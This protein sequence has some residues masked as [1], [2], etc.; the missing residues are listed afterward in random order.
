MSLE[1]LK[2][3]RNLFLCTAINEWPDLTKNVA[4]SPLRPKQENNNRTC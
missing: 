4:E 1:L 3:P 2:L